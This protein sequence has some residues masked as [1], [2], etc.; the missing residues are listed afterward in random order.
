M[1]KYINLFYII[2]LI[3]IFVINNYINQNILSKIRK[4]DFDK[5]CT[6]GIIMKFDRFI[7]DSRIKKIYFDLVKNKNIY[8]ILN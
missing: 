3:I 8:F 2:Y 5:K 6:F 1:D 7:L 4:V